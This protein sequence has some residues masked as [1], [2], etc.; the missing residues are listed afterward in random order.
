M[1]MLSFP[2]AHDGYGILR[3]GNYEIQIPPGAVSNGSGDT[4]TG[5]YY[6]GFWFLN[7]DIDRNR[8]VDAT[9]YAIVDNGFVNHLSGW[10]SGDLDYN[11]V[12]DGSD[13][14]ILDNSFVNRL[15]A[16]TDFYVFALPVDP[17]LGNVMRL[18]WTDNV[19]NEAYWRVE[20]AEAG[21]SYEVLTTL[22]AGSTSHDDSNLPDGTWYSYRVKAVDGWGTAIVTTPKRGAVTVLPPPTGVSAAA[23]PT[24]GIEL[25]WTDPTNAEIAYSIERRDGAS[26]QVFQEVGAAFADQTSWIDYSV[27]AGEAYVYRISAVNANARS[28]PSTPTSPTIAPAPQAPN[29]LAHLAPELSA[30]RTALQEIALEWTDKTAG[31]VGFRIFRRIGESGTWDLLHQA[32]P[33]RTQFFDRGLPTTTIASYHLYAF[34][35]FGVTPPSNIVTVRSPTEVHAVAATSTSIDVSW[36]F[37]WTDPAKFYVDAIDRARYLKYGR[38]PLL[39]SIAGFQRVAELPGSARSHRVSGLVDG[40][41]YFFVVIAQDA[42][43]TSGLNLTSETMTEPAP[44]IAP[45]PP[46][47]LQIQRFNQTAFNLTWQDKSAGNAGYVIRTRRDSEPFDSGLYIPEG[48]LTQYSLGLSGSTQQSTTYE[49]EVRAYT[50]GDGVGGVRESEPIRQTV[51]VPTLPTSSPQV[52]WVSITPGSPQEGTTGS[53]TVNGGSIDNPVTVDLLLFG[54]ATYGVDY[55]IPMGLSLNLSGSPIQVPVTGVADYLLE[56]DETI[57]VVALASA[58][59]WGAIATMALGDAGQVPTITPTEV[60]YRAHNQDHFKAVERDDG[61][62]TYLGPHWKDNS[63]TPDGDADDPG[64]RKYPVAYV[65]GGAM[66]VEAKFKLPDGFTPPGR[67]RVRGN[68]TYA[69]QFYGD[70]DTPNGQDGSVVISGSTVTVMDIASA[71]FENY[72]NHFDPFVIEWQISLD[73]G[74]TWSPGGTTKNQVYVLLGDPKFAPSTPQKLFHTVVH[75]GTKNAKGVGDA[76]EVPEK[77]WREFVDRDV[78][79]A[80]GKRLTYYADWLTQNTHTA[81]LLADANGDGQCGAWVHL[82]I[83]LLRAQGIDGV[84]EWIEVVPKRSD[85]TGLLIQDWNF[86]SEGGRSGNPTYG[87]INLY[88]RSVLGPPGYYWTVADVS[89]DVNGIPGQGKANPLSHFERH[90]IV[91]IQVDPEG[92]SVYLDPSYGVMYLDSDGFEKA[93]I[94]GIFQDVDRIEDERVWGADLNRNGTAT[95]PAVSVDAFLIRRNLPGDGEDVRFHLRDDAIMY[96]R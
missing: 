80:D 10:S 34:G 69:Y 73:D 71:A 19:T 35:P 51:V 2:D 94:A 1:T 91:K 67:V 6:G 31:E 20:R 65:R 44:A 70:T 22:P 25:T 53:F 79:R 59:H 63:A 39:A 36:T 64:D 56:G 76:A 90:H 18:S 17:V 26:G 14:S 28:A 9:D 33:N 49:I 15:P 81:M 38:S 48:S 11:G 29:P 46:E 88:Y 83:D 47:N 5:T 43:G 12:I 32:G 4:M 57:T 55:T 96:G 77:L 74:K 84:T 58:S 87:Y 50:F 54:S 13:Y 92:G 41:T 30:R 86:R 60:T 7:G 82:Y 16:V 68:T 72:I 93:A 42:D 23:V 52:E 78:R 27:S 21:G 85:A 45:L 75:L 61:T 89:D 37:P 95:E 24:G 66:A 8:V 62:G 3:N 40:E